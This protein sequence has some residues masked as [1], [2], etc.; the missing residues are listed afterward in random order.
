MVWRQVPLADIRGAL[1]AN[2]IFEILNLIQQLFRE[3]T[4]KEI[5]I[6]DVFLTREA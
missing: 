1:S 4:K 5:I 3:L 2:D 6:N